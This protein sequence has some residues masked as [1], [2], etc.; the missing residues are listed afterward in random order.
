ML[1][2]SLL[3]FVLAEGTSLSTSGNR[4]RPGPAPIGLPKLTHLT[5]Q[6]LASLCA[7]C[8]IPTLLWPHSGLLCE[9]TLPRPRTPLLPGRP[10]LTCG[11]AGP[12]LLTLPPGRSPC[13]PARC[14]PGCEHICGSVSKGPK[15]RSTVVC[16]QPQ[17]L[18]PGLMGHFQAP[19]H[20]P[21]HAT[22]P[23][24]VS[25]CFWGPSYN[26]STGIQ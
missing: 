17:V 8:R 7:T 26:L 19:T 3:C 1:T 15:V 6:S 16:Q 2:Y 13:F 22:R 18:G 5:V 20:A 10:G 9:F 12:F 14:A 4:F 11:S 23:T 21:G 24:S 25:L